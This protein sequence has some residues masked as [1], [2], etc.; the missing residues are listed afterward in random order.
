MPVPKVAQDLPAESPKQV[1]NLCPGSRAWCERRAPAWMRGA[2]NKISLPARSLAE[3]RVLT[4]ASFPE[5][6]EEIL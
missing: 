3:D 4:A 6:G 1:C 2:H 5:R